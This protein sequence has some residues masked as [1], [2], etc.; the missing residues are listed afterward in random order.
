M[1]AERPLPLGK[2]ATPVEWKCTIF[3]IICPKTLLAGIRPPIVSVSLTFWI[4]TSGPLD[5][6]SRDHLRER[7]ISGQW[8]DLMSYGNE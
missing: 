3:L 2:N 1:W 5:E 6:Q 8:P 7:S 4:L